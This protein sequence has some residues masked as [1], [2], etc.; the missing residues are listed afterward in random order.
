MTKK[1][2]NKGVDSENI[3]AFI[4]GSEFPDEIVVIS[5]FCPC[6]AFIWA[7]VKTKLSD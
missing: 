2:G 4:P 7:P 6:F 1:F 3:W 5:E